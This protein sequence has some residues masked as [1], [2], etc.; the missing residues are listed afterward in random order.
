MALI[1][2]EII[3]TS[4]FFRFFFFGMVLLNPKS[5]EIHY[6]LFLFSECLGHGIVLLRA[7]L[8]AFL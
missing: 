5:S 6:F 4:F 1:I 3:G 7:A 8:F 2:P